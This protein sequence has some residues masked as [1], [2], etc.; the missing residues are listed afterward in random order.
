MVIFHLSLVLLIAV[1]TIMVSRTAANHHGA[2]AEQG[3]GTFYKAAHALSPTTD[4]VIKHRYHII[5]GRYLMPLIDNAKRFGGPKIK[6]MEI[7]LG[8]N[9]QYG[10]G[11]SV[12][13]WKSIGGEHFDLWEADYDEPCV[14]EA[15][16]AGKL[17]GMH[18]LVG[19]QANYTTLHRWVEESGG[20]FDVVI[21]DGGHHFDMIWHSFEVLWPTVK[22]GGYYF[23]E[24]LEHD[25]PV[26]NKEGLALQDWPFSWVIQHWIDMLHHVPVRG[27]YPQMLWQSPMYNKGNMFAKYPLPKNVEAI[28]CSMGICL[29]IKCMGDL[30][31]YGCAS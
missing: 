27:R 9:M 13:L 2:S 10:S 28:T 11:A 6:F 12:G 8:C 19:D 31:Y 23:I 17:T 4:K 20:N 15:T 1:A 3:I 21:D 25:A 7:G 18:T 30:G 22:P 16:A 5:Y 14:K 24:D 26:D 29:I